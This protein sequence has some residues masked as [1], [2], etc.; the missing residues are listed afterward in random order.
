MTETIEKTICEACGADVR[1]NTVF[2][3]NCGSKLELEN[4]LE[5][6]GAAVADE[7]SKAALDD[8]ANKLTRE[9]GDE[10]AK[11]ATK[12]KKARV[13][14]RK[15]NEFTWEPRED[16]SFLAMVFSV[17][18]AFIALIIVILLVVWR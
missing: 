11:A 12:R 15:R 6:N 5:K 16:S 2:C 1:D 10:L 18:I 3:Y 9:S 7:N 13:M 14:H 4:P 17:L 8:L